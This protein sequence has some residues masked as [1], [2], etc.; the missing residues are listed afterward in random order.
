[1]QHSGKKNLPLKKVLL[2]ISWLILFWCVF[3][4]YQKMQSP[5]FLPIKN[6]KITASY[7]HIEPQTLETIILP[8]VTHAG[9][10]SIDMK[11][12]KSAML[13]Q[14]PWIDQVYIKR[15]WPDEID[16][17]VVEQTPVAVWNDKT[18][19]NIKD[20]IFAASKDSFPDGLPYLN[21]SD[22]QIVLTQYQKFNNQLKPLHLA[23]VQLTMNSRGSWEMLLTN[24]IQIILGRT[25][26]ENRFAQFI[27]IYPR[28]LAARE[29]Q[30]Q[31]VD[32]RY[33]DGLAVEWK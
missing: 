29:D 32:L 21:G 25:D 33:S 8:Y 27:K 22:P 15:I 24:H 13:G 14:L 26:I 1:M 10:F 7:E 23:I 3:F 30:I 11:L 20:E 4:C 31:N 2:I 5:D 12:L 19:M 17:I 6:V 28:I 16:V 9:L 18:L